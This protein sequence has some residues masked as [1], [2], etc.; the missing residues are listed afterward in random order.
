MQAILQSTPPTQSHTL[1]R[2]YTISTMEA[3]TVCGVYEN[4]GQEQLATRCRD[5]AGRMP[6]V[7]LFSCATS[8]LRDISTSR[9]PISTAFPPS[10]LGPL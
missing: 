7:R 4:P 8:H 5:L 6:L 10:C 2:K 1:Q 9:Q 3:N